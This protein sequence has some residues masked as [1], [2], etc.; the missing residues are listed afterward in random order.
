MNHLQSSNTTA[1]VDKPS[2]KE[3]LLLKGK[4]P[5][6]QQDFFTRE[7]APNSIYEFFTSNGYLTPEE[8]AQIFSDTLEIP[9]VRLD[10]FILAEEFK[11]LDPSLLISDKI[12]PYRRT[13]NGVEIVMANPLDL[14]LRDRMSRLLDTPVFPAV[15]L[16]NEIVKCVHLNFS[17]Q[18]VIDEMVRDL[19]S[20]SRVS[21]EE[22]LIFENLKNIENPI[23]KLVN[24][25][26]L[27]ALEK[28]A[29]DIHI[30][31]YE[32]RMKVKYRIDGILQEV[33]S[34]LDRGLQEQ[35]VSRIKIM[36]NLDI[37][38]KR[39]PQDGR[40]RLNIKG[41]S[42]DFRVSILP[43]IF[44]EA[45][46]I[47]VLDKQMLSLDLEQLGFYPEQIEVFRK[48]V[49]LPY[50]MI[51]VAG[52]TGSGKTTTLYAT[53]K[54]IK[55]PDDKFITIEDPVEY[56][57]PDIVQ[58]P[59][60]DKK[61]L[62]FE[63]GLRSIV[64]HDPDKI[65]VGEIRDFETADIA[66]NAALT[67]HLVFSTIHANNV[68]DS[69]FRLIN[70]G[71]ESYQFIAAFNLIMTQRLVRKICPF[72]KEPAGEYEGT[73]IFAGRGC[74]H[75][76]FTG[77]FE[78]TA[79]FE[80]FPLSDTIKEMILKKNTPMEIEAQARVEGIISLREAALRKLRDGATTLYEVNRVTHSKK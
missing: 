35:L 24:S 78:R 77:H 56:Q 41:R 37:A 19:G 16:E 27:N 18:S 11:T 15:G 62:T 71:I 66:V 20:D 54:W 43:S 13:T 63:K 14:R 51:L 73:P 72:C 60:N 44:G 64:R 32:T 26:V 74:E 29:S 75:C 1:H 28:R 61:G 30:E 58:I 34:D 6:N 67:G 39:V 52:P 70:L 49:R 12:I 69:I 68:I 45:V 22:E 5:R 3:T 55:T 65:M 17:T 47:R 21:D 76:S 33:T 79:I 80:V 8:L 57:L 7:L 31:S 59:V 53:L 9:L 46:V 2:L 23:I 4:L 48:N 50:G 25:L 40:F 38:E 42:V 10:E 36:A